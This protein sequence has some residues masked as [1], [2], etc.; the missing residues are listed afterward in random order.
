MLITVSL[1]LPS[2]L[3]CLLLG[4]GRCGPE[5]FGVIQYGFGVSATDGREL[6][7]AGLLIERKPF[8]GG[9]RGRG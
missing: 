8:A 4:F 6:V 9:G 7:F 3:C 2:Q 5:A 1:R